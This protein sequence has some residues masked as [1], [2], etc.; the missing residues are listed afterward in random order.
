M[1]FQILSTVLTIV[2]LSRS[3]F[4]IFKKYLYFAPDKMMNVKLSLSDVDDEF[5]TR[6]Q[7]ISNFLK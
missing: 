3:N 5:Q 1:F 2:T 6:I 4:N 7:L